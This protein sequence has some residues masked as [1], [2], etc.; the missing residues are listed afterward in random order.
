MVLANNFREMFNL[1]GIGWSLFLLTPIPVIAFRTRFRSGRIAAKKSL[2]PIVLADSGSTLGNFCWCGGDWLGRS[3]TS[4]S[5][6]LRTS[7]SKFRT[8][9]RFVLLVN[10]LPVRSETSAQFPLH[11]LLAGRDWKVLPRD[12]RII[13]RATMVAA[14]C[15]HG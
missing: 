14:G 9:Q 8:F 1:L 2:I 12:L 4:H 10:L 3:T 13:Q 5:A 15:L 6:T 11:G 7:T